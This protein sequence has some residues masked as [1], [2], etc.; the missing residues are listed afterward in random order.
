MKYL[1][2][3]FII[4]VSF[5]RHDAVAAAV[6]LDEH[7]KRRM[8][9]LAAAAGEW[10]IVTKLTD[11]SRERS[12]G[13]GAS[14]AAAEGDDENFRY[15]LRRFLVRDQISLTFGASGEIISP[16]SAVKVS[17]VFNINLRDYEFKREEDPVINY[18]K[19][20]SLCN[21]RVI[22]LSG[23]TNTTR[24]I[25]EVFADN[26]TQ[27]KYYSL[28]RIIVN[29]ADF[30]LS[31]LETSL[32]TIFTHFSG[33]PRFIRDMQQISG[34]YDV[35]AAFLSVELS[36]WSFKGVSPVPEGLDIIEWQRGKKDK[37]A[38]EI[39]HRVEGTVRGSFIMTV[40]R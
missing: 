36:P 32:N 16:T 4:A 26:D 17:K 24:F 11:A 18:F 15:A 12:Y 31:T 1:V 27:R 30:D 6:D 23:A 33:Y 20:N 35:V 39:H 2:I 5:V 29:G 8:V 13:C 3:I 34:R 7:E 38:H 37:R 9:S 14:V 28:L 19:D 40:A 21:L 10:E 22:D 25:T